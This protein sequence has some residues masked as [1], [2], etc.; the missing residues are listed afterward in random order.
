MDSPSRVVG[1]TLRALALAAVA[2]PG[3]NAQTTVRPEPTIAPVGDWSV[4]AGYQDFTYRDV[5]RVG[6]PVDA[7]PIGWRTSGPALALRRDRSHPARLHRWDVTLSLGEHASYVGPVGSVDG[8]SGDQLTR[9][10]VRYEYRRYLFVDKLPKWFDAGL[11]AQAIGDVLSM[12]RHLPP[13][14]EVGERDVRA[15]GALV[16]AARLRP[17]P[18]LAVEA[19]WANGAVLARIWQHHSAG[20]AA[21]VSGWGGGW[22]TDLSVRGDLH[23]AGRSS[24]IV[25]YVRSGEGLLSTHHEYAAQSGRLSVGVRHGM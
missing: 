20:A 6:P 18:R 1:R 3:A 23:I 15:G 22:L 12:S 2:A 9:V 8:G 14:I 19:A 7:S 24:L 11:G 5:A 17:W 25:D 4:V 10:G 13:S 16:A 21:S